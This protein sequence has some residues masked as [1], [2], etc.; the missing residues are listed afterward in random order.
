MGKIE[1]REPEDV[2]EAKK[3]KQPSSVDARETN[4]FQIELRG[5]ALTGKRTILVQKSSIKDAR[6][7]E[8]HCKKGNKKGRVSG[9]TRPR[10]NRILKGSGAHTRIL[11]IPLGRKN[12]RIPN[13]RS[14]ATSGGMW[15]LKKGVKEQQQEEGTTHYPVTWKKEN[16]L[17]GPG[18]E[19]KKNELIRSSVAYTGKR[20]KP[21]VPC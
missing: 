6:N 20:G 9:R 14:K 11:A 10:K 3:G 18:E 7:A 4:R 17:G 5:Y 21:V 12:N 13:P 8:S 19:T 2:C 1:R 15:I 16:A